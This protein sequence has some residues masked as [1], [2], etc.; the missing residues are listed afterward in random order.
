VK[1]RAVIVT[2]ALAGAFVVS[3]CTALV[4]TAGLSGGPA[5]SRDGGD[6]D[7][8]GAADALLEGAASDA[9]S[10]TAA[11]CRA[12][13]A[14]D[15][16]APSGVYPL[17]GSD[18]GSFTAYCDMDTADGGWTLVTPAMIVEEKRSQDAIAG[19]V[20]TVDVTHGIDSHGGLTLKVNVLTPNCGANHSQGADFHSFLVGELDAWKEIRA[21][22]EFFGG[23]SCW[24][25][26]GD[27][28]LP[29][30]NV[31]ALDLTRDLFDLEQNMA[32]AENGTVLKYSGTTM[33]CSGAR[34]NFWHDDY[35]S[36]RRTAR[37]ALRRASMAKPAGLSI[38]TDCS[39]TNS[40]AY[41]DIFVR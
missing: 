4:S 19:S 5:P 35:T 21:T 11:S 13:H 6:G 41:T 31:F 27:Q 16:A 33:Q 32:R 9:A 17:R 20:A 18:G 34:A 38:A 1:K 26:F 40:W 10:P 39:S 23:V 22:Y 30:T 7:G 37:V 25:I 24:N 36:S 14:D 15:V 3:A 12:L 8:G 29:D 28:G 2:A